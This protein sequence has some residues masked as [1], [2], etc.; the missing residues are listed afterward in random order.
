MY[1]HL[2]VAYHHESNQHL[3]QRGE[4]WRLPHCLLPPSIQFCL[5]CLSS[6]ISKDQASLFIQPMKATH[7]TLTPLC[8]C[9]LYV[10]GERKSVTIQWYDNVPARCQSITNIKTSANVGITFLEILGSKVH[11]NPQNFSLLWVLSFVPQ[12]MM[13]KFYYWKNNISKS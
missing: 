4:P 12:N 3:S 8:V 7:R 1:R 13:E 9:V 6:A 10:Y 11:Q 5:H 2:T